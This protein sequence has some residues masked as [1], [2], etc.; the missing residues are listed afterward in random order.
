MRSGT[1]RPSP[2]RKH[3]REGNAYQNAFHNHGGKAVFGGKGNGGTDGQ[4]H[5]IT[6][7][8][9]AVQ[10][11]IAHAQGNGT[12]HHEGDGRGKQGDKQIYAFKC[13]TAHSKRAVPSHVEEREHE[14]LMACVPEQRTHK[15]GIEARLRC[16]GMMG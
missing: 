5:R 1:E 6:P 7:H 3:A 15:N 2:R 12:Q 14:R 11:H 13:E 9:R 4:Q 8:K 16:A 10:Q